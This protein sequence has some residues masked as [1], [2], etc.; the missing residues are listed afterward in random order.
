M[1]TDLMSVHSSVHLRHVR[2]SYR[3]GDTDRRVFE[4]LDLVIPPGAF[5]ALLGRS[6]SGKSTLLNL[7]AG[8]DLPDAGDVQVGDQVI[9]RLTE[10]ERT[11]FRRRLGF[12]FQFFNLIPTLTVE[13]NVLL[14]LELNGMNTDEGRRH[15]FEL[16]AQVGLGERRRSFPE[17]LSGGEQQR[18]AI[19]R[20]LAHQPPLLLADE[21]TGNLDDDTGVRVMDLL[22]ALQR[23]FGITVLMVTHSREIAARA[24]RVLVLEA[25]RIRESAP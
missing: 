17:R 13:E 22:F 25:G 9:N 15:A 14:P 1:P 5:V 11:G 16:L 8:I 24:E 2:K 3:E 12:I 10:Y 4:D 20:A 23:R 7:V 18:L 19:V 21:P 6:G